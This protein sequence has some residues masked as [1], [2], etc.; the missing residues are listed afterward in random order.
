VRARL[1]KNGIETKK[2]KN[3]IHSATMTLTSNWG[4]GMVYELEQ[5]GPVSVFDNEQHGFSESD[6]NL[7][8]LLPKLN[9]LFLEF[10]RD[11]HAEHAID[12]VLLPCSGKLILKDTLKRIREELGIPTVNQWLDCKQNFEVGLGPYGQDMGQKDIAPEFDLVWTSSRSACEWYM[13]V[14]ATPIFL[15]EGFSPK[16]TPRIGCKKIYDVGFLGMCYGLRPD[17]I[18][19][20][21]KAG[22]KVIARGPGWPLPEGKPVP[23]DE[24]GRFFGLCKV[25]LGFGGVGYS[26]QLTT[27]KGRDF[28]VPG[29]GGAYLTTYNP[30]LAEFFHIGHEILCYHSIDDMIEQARRIAYDD[31][32]RE[33]LAA[34]AYERSMREHRW[35]NRFNTILEILGILE[36]QT[37]K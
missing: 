7:Q 19:K 24:M 26:M 2:G 30:D 15:P 36:Q 25:N 27:L 20:L 17:Y 14:G 4:L 6:P 23:L 28:E 1:E 31:S 13:A 29:A 11:R 3:S 9:R 35:L 34:R 8:K 10:L 21:R 32:F 12:W 18:E 33:E 37:M 22:L 16:L 5:L